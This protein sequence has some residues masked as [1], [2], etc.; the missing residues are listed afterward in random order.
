M[1]ATIII[2]QLAKILKIVSFPNYTNDVPKKVDDNLI[3]QHSNFDLFQVFPLPILYFGNLVCGLGGTKH[4]SLPMFTVL[5]RFTILMTVI[6]EYIVLKYG[7]DYLEL[8]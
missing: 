6:G 2:L 8:N 7:I 1:I 4:L 3:I 5:R